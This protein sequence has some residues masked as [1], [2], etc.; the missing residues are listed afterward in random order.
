MTGSSTVDAIGIAVAEAPKPR[1]ARVKFSGR[2]S[3]E[4][5]YRVEPSADLR[6]GQYAV[7]RKNS[8]LVTI[9]AVDTEPVPGLDLSKYD[10]V[11]PVPDE[12]VK[13]EVTE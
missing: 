8:S 13:E 6:P 1:F 2:N 4:Y 11:Y 9:T 7:T 5:I 3:K 10:W 12:T